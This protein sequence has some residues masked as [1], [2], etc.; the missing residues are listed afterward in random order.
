MTRLETG[1]TGTHSLADAGLR[2]EFVRCPP[3]PDLDWSEGL[4]APSP[5]S[6]R[7]LARRRAPW[8]A[9]GAVIGPISFTVG[10]LVLGWLSP[11]FYTARGTRLAPYSAV[12][13]QISRLGVG[14]TALFMNSIFE[15][16]GILT[17][18]GVLGIVGSQ[19]RGDHRLRMVFVLLALPALGSMMD[20]IFTLRY[21]LMH[22]VGFALALTSMVGIPV[23]GRLLRRNPPWDRFG[24]WLVVAGPLTLVLAVSFLASL[25]PSIRQGIAGLTERILVVEITSWYIALG[26]WAFASAV[27]RASPQFPSHEPPDK[28]REK[29]IVHAYDERIGSVGSP[30]NTG[31][32]R[33]VD[34][35]FGGHQ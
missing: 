16:S 28:H 20:G 21:E 13:Q 17:L 3:T 35:T 31:R 4:R 11:G 7:E 9:L 25:T 32:S 6:F 27:R 33:D 12:T 1:S 8:L 18:I 26:W 29:P 19:P 24:N 5:A 23:A 30:G 10:W 34:D 22:S 14:P 15:V 2:S